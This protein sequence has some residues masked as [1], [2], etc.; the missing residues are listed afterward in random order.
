MV[1]DQRIERSLEP[2]EQVLWSGRPRQ[3]LILRA[4]DALIIPY[5]LLFVV[6]VA[7]LAGSV[8][9]GKL[10]LVTIVVGV[11]A[12]LPLARLVFGRFLLDGVQRD[13]TWYAVTDSRVLIFYGL[14][15][16]RMRSLDLRALY[17]IEVEGNDRRATIWFGHPDRHWWEMWSL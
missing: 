4:S 15:T 13:R 6:F 10:G 1:D 7:P 17:D 16:P 5:S 12:L 11:A 8:M 14:L 3:G 9:S 2:G